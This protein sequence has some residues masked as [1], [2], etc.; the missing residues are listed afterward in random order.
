MYYCVV[1]FLTAF[2]INNLLV[3]PDLLDRISLSHQ[4]FEQHAHIHTALCI[5]LHWTVFSVNAVEEFLYVA[6]Q[7]KVEKRKDNEYSP[8]ITNSGLHSDM[9]MCGPCRHRQT[10][11]FKSHGQHGPSLPHKYRKHKFWAALVHL[12]VWFNDHYLQRWRHSHQS[13]L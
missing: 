7:E 4:H 1:F 5:V 11:K 8:Q 6:E 12:H 2:K 13:Q 3:Q 9:Y 10:M